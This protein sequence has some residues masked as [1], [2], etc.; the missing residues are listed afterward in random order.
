MTQY[1]LQPGQ[2]G[3]ISDILTMLDTMT[4]RLGSTESDNEL[5]RSLGMIGT[6]AALAAV[7]VAR[8]KGGT[9]PDIAGIIKTL[10]R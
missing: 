2:T 5:L 8:N 3:V 10:S 4:D 7:M 9:S 1:E 6:A